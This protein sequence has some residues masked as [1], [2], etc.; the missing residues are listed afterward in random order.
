M[1]DVAQKSSE[2]YAKSAAKQR[3]WWQNMTDAERA[4]YERKRAAG[5]ARYMERKKNARK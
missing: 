5:I 1:S 3:L 2:R 4:E